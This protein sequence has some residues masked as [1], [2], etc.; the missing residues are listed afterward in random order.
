MI[1][2]QKFNV[3][4]HFTWVMGRWS[5]MDDEDILPNNS[6]YKNVFFSFGW[7]INYNFTKQF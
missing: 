2:L 7:K 6:F 1:L 4:N 5:D 3:C